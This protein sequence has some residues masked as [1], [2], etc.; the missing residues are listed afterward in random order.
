MLKNKKRRIT[1]LLLIAVFFI[2]IFQNKIPSNAVEGQR[3][4][5]P[6]SELESKWYINGDKL[7]YDNYAKQRTGLTAYGAIGCTISRC[8]SG[9]KELANGPLTEWISMQQNEDFAEE[10]VYNQVTADM[11]PVLFNHREYSLSGIYDKIVAKGYTEW[12]SE[13][14]RYYIDHDTTADVVYLRLDFICETRHFVGYEVDSFYFSSGDYDF[15]YDNILRG[16]IFMNDPTHDGDNPHNLQYNAYDPLTGNHISWS[17]KAISDME[18]YFNIYLPEDET[19]PMEV[20]PGT[21]VSLYETRNYS[22][23]YDISMAIPSGETVTNNVSASSF[24]GYLHVGT[25]SSAPT[26]YSTTYEYYYTVENTSHSLVY[27]GYDAVFVR[28]DYT[29][30]PFGNG[31][32]TYRGNGNYEYTPGRGW[33]N[34]TAIYNNIGRGDRDENGNYQEHGYYE[35]QDLPAGTFTDYIVGTKTFTYNVRVEFQYINDFDIRRLNQMI[36]YNNAFSG[37]NITYNADEFSNK[38]VTFSSHIYSQHAASSGRTYDSVG[39]GTDMSSYDYTPRILSHC[40]LPA[41]DIVGSYHR[42]NVGHSLSASEL[43]AQ[44]TNDATN[45]Q[46][47]IANGCTSWNDEFVLNDNGSVKTFMDDT[48]VTGAIFSDGSTEWKVGNVASQSSYATTNNALESFVSSLSAQRSTAGKTKAIPYTTPNGDYPTGLSATWESLVGKG[49]YTLNAGNSFGYADDIYNHVMAGGVLSHH[50]SGDNYPIRVH[51]P[52]IA[53][54]EIVFNDGTPAIE[55]T[56]LTTAA[57]NTGA[58]F[59]LLLDKSYYLKFDNEQWYSQLYGAPPGYGNSMDRFVLKKTVRFPFGVVYNGV[60][61]PRT[62]TGYTQWIEVQRPGSVDTPW[63]DSAD[64][65]KYESNNHYQMMPFYIPSFSDEVGYNG[66]NAFVEVAVYAYNFTGTPLADDDDTAVVIESSNRLTNEYLATTRRQV[67]TSGWLYD[68]SVVGT[69][70]QVK[71]TGNGLLDSNIFD[72]IKPWSL[73]H[74]KYEMKSSATNRVGTDNIRFL[75]DGSLCS[76][77]LNVIQ[78]LPLRNGQSLFSAGYGNVWLGETFAFTVKTISNLYGNNDSIRVIPH[79]KYVMHD[80]TILDEDAGDFKI[81]MVDDY[82]GRMDVTEF[83][84]SDTTLSKGKS[85]NLNDEIFKDAY[86]DQHDC[87][88]YQQ[89]GNWAVTSADNENDNNAAFGYY[90]SITPEEFLSRRTVSYDINSI[91]IPGSLR[92][93]S[94]EYEQLEMNDGCSYDRATGSTTLTTYWNTIS[95][96]DDVYEGRFKRSMQQWHSCY[97]VPT[98]IKLVDTRTLGGNLFDIKD[99]INN[100]NQFSWEST[101]IQIRDN[102]VLVVYFEI[103]AYKGNMPYMNYDGVNHIY[104]ANVDVFK[105]TKDFVEPGIL[106]IN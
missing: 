34:R 8:K 39:V 72:K 105:S 81:Y 42:I 66:N 59:E 101:P 96:Y 103:M 92:L 44:I 73:A 60:F 10:T 58:N 27:V 31:D 80:G 79:Y 83:D 85:V 69:T 20:L 74:V 71:Y 5:I 97:Q 51:T 11:V 53:P 29:F 67:Q 7:C 100:T 102:G 43:Q 19:A 3:I 91:I 45:I 95:N 47:A 76:G 98:N 35:Y 23:T 30:M 82:P 16:D 48:V 2:N 9:E 87:F 13:F 84:P 4:D 104:I 41:S 6:Y 36:V 1:A 21:S 25:A 24:T 57:F 63:N 38:N 17:S 65:S 94:G 62:G 18:K 26:T 22:P 90:S 33:W 15:D 28:Y 68:F 12:A 61:Y 49:P 77:P 56:Q 40:S 88:G 46:N 50:S 32:W 54:I 55:A 37:G 99:Y 52:I 75:S 93:C 64:A 70:N 106:N 89:Y 14:K 78:T 86:Y